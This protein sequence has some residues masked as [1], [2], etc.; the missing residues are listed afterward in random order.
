MQSQIYTKRFTQR[1]IYAKLE[2]K[3]DSKNK[4]GFFSRKYGTQN[5]I[6]A[7]QNYAKQD[8][9]KVRFMQSEICKMYAKRDLHKARFTKSEI[10]TKPDLCKARFMQSEISKIYAKRDLQDVCKARFTQS[11]IYTK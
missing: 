3:H 9:C 10:Y 5:K 6:Y 4:R 11:E 7:E 2:N 1:E 8:L